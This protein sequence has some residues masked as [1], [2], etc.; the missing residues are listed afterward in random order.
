MFDL[1]DSI[2][3]HVSSLDETTSVQCTSSASKRAQPHPNSHHR[4]SM[5]RELSA[6][7]HPHLLLS[8]PTQNGG[9]G[10]H[11]PYDSAILLDDR[12]HVLLAP[13]S[14]IPREVSV[15]SDPG[16]HEAHTQQVHLPDLRFWR[17]VVIKSKPSPG[18]V[19][20]D[21]F[22]VFFL[23]SQPSVSFSFLKSN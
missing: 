16:C 15:P 13:S 8:H 3:N 14:R 9:P 7:F 4:P 10:I 5:R 21:V 17:M 2:K 20:S 11:P 6:Y 1:L 22:S 23:E 19:Q 18:L 12:V